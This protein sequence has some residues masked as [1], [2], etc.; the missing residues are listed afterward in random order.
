MSVFQAAMPTGSYPSL[1]SG[2]VQCAQLYNNADLNDCVPENDKVF[3]AWVCTSNGTSNTMSNT[4]YANFGRTFY[5]TAVKTWYDKQ[6]A[7]KFRVVQTLYSVS[8]G[9]NS[10]IWTRS[11]DGAGTLGWSDWKEIVVADGSYPSLTAGTAD[12]LNSRLLINTTTANIGWWKVGELDISDCT[13]ANISYSCIM[14]INGLHATQFS[15]ATSMRESGIIEFDVRKQDSALSNYN[16][17]SI[18]AGNIPTDEVCIA[19]SGNVVSLYV[20]IDNAYG[21]ETFAVINE[22][23]EIGINTQ[24]FNFNASFYGTTAPEGAVYAVVRNRAS[25]DADGNELVNTSTEQTISGR[26]NFAQSGANNPIR[27]I[28]AWEKTGNS[29]TRFNYIEFLDSNNSRTGVIGQKT[30]GTDRYGVYLQCGNEGSLQVLSD[31]E[32]IYFLLSENPPATDNTTSIATT[33][34]VNDKGYITAI[35]VASQTVLG[36]VKV[37][38]D[39]DGY[40]CIDTQ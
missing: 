10:L 12:A 13:G 4:P 19:I 3:Q 35:P 29:T 40:F 23:S 26:K 11:I 28:S 31:G 16:G 20:K 9:G 7:D 15:S 21:M 1:M 6:N 2:G 5:L 27:V 37:Y 38:T 34:W 22:T 30:A 32:N 25:T 14:L 17:V 33:K 18:L 8:S 24:L 36:G 39:S